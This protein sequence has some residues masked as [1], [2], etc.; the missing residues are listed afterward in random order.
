MEQRIKYKDTIKHLLKLLSMFEHDD[1]IKFAVGWLLSI[2]Q[3]VPI[4]ILPIIYRE[5]A[6]TITNNTN[7]FSSIILMVVFL[8]ISIP[9]NVYGNYIRANAT[10]HGINKA[11]AKFFSYII[12]Q[13]YGTLTNKKTGEYINRLTSDMNTAYQVFQGY[14]F[15]ALVKS[16]VITLFSIATMIFISWEFVVYGIIGC[17]ICVILATRLNPIVRRLETQAKSSIDECSTILSETIAG[18]VVIRIFLLTKV[19]FDKYKKACNIIFLNRSHYQTVQGAVYGLIDGVVYV[20][21]LCGFILGSILIS[22]G[23]SNIADVVY[24]VSVLN[25]LMQAMLDFSGFANFIQP[26]IVSAKRI[27]DVLDTSLANKTQAADSTKDLDKSKQTALEF[28]N[29][30]FSYKDTDKIVLKNIS[31]NVTTG[32]K[33]GFIGS[34]G[35]GKTTIIK[36]IEKF[37]VPTGGKIIFFGEDLN[38]IDENILRENLSYI[39]QECTL[40]NVSIAQNIEYGKL[41]ATLD[42]IKSAAKDANIHD[43][44]E[45]LPNGY[46][47]MIGEDGLG[48]SGGQKQR[49]SIAR[50]ILRNAPIILLDEPTSALDS[51]TEQEILQNM[52]TVFEEKTVIT[53]S[54]RFNILEGYDVIYNLV[55]G[56]IVEN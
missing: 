32:T 17:I 20:L 11:K 49:V 53:I 37:Y 16:I 6:D 33:I 43:F 30:S 54:H 15:T 19:I 38:N 55:D 34:S 13:D 4:I 28:D 52:R 56:N 10:N 36:L 1:Q 24:C 18:R 46:N 27:F 8:V 42:E 23:K 40:F 29:V 14:I 31:F 26:T 9:I 48:L 7:N 21:P 39:P 35:A 51:Q 41:G 45:S 25:I 3:F 12:K 5:F 50:A 22:Y 44:I 47:T 2:F